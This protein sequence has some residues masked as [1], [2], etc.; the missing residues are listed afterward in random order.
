MRSPEHT[1]P[2]T[3]QDA[4]AVSCSPKITASLA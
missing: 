4:Q 2:D 1:Q 3:G